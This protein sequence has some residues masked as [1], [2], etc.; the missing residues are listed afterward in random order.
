MSD[1]VRRLEDWE[2][3]HLRRLAD[4]YSTPL[5]V[6]DLA[7]L[8]A[9]Y[10]RLDAAF[11]AATVKY[12]A[13]AN[14]GQHV[15]ETLVGMG[16]AIECGSPGEVDRALAAGADPATTQYTAVNPPGPALERACELAAETPAFTV[17]AGAMDT[18]DRLAD[19]GFDGRLLLRVN[20]GIGAGHHEKVVTGT[21]PKFGVPSDR[22]SE[23]LS[24]AVDR[25]LDVRGLHAHAGSGMLGDDTDA[26]RAFCERMCEFVAG[27]PIPIETVDIG[28]GLGVPYH[29]DEA[30]LDVDAVAAATREAFDGVEVDLVLEPGRYVVADA[31]VLLTEVNTVKPT[32]ETT[33][34]GIDAGMTTLLRPALYDAYHPVRNLAPDAADRERVACTV[35][36]PICETSDVLATDRPLASPARGDRLAVGNAGAYGYEMALQFHSQPRPAAVALDGDR[37]GVARRRE[38]VEDIVRVEQPLGWD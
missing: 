2:P 32:A 1:A 26:H 6:L 14:A 37:E 7:R 11:D 35:G 29:E 24:H 36:G 13:K 25:G 21:N 10:R 18:V 9:N 15:L 31:G 8:R 23:V 12:A 16:V 34:V 17:T 4:E 28:G 3:D 5:Y 38:T 20:P 22:V 27:A 19:R 30:P 33:V